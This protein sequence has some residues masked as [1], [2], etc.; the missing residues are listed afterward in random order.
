MILFKDHLLCPIINGYDCIKKI[1]FVL[2]ISLPL[3]IIYQINKNIFFA[4]FINKKIILY[5]FS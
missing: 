3:D 1:F 4:I 5:S 2:F